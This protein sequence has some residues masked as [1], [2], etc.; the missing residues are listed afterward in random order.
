MTKNR[1]N[2]A[3][4]SKTAH[5]VV[6]YMSVKFLLDTSILV[7]YTVPL[8]VFKFNAPSLYKKELLCT[9][10]KLYM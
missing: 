8:D 2:F 6:S 10:E 5:L 1:L 7:H 3:N 9:L 4:T